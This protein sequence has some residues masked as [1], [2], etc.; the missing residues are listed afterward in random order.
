MILRGFGITNYLIKK[1]MYLSYDYKNT[2]VA[3]TLNDT[4]TNAGSQSINIS[5][6]PGISGQSIIVTVNGTQVTYTTA[7][8][9]V[10]F[11]I[12][13]PGNNTFSISAGIPNPTPTPGPTATPTPTPTT[14]PTP[15]ATS[16]PT[17]TPTDLALNKTATASAYYGAGYEVPKGVDGNDTTRWASGT[18]G[19]GEWYKV[20]LGSSYS[21]TKV[22]IK[23][24]AAYAVNYSIAVSTDGT[25]FTTVKTVTGGAGGNTNDTFTAINARYVKINLTGYRSGYNC[26]SFWTLSV[27]Q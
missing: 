14:T 7:N 16:T 19:S 21:I 9:I 24:E 11:N 3:G 15:T 22:P 26:F 6:P 20:D 8:N 27:Y 17:P 2:S 18:S 23:W 13:L 12:P 4:Q 25:N 10:T 1:G 5:I